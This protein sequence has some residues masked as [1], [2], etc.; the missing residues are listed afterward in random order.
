MDISDGA[1]RGLASLSKKK[2][3]TAAMGTDPEAEL[4]QG[5]T[6]KDY[7]IGEAIEEEGR[8]VTGEE[9]MTFFRLKQ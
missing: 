6:I 2:P 8:E 4:I 5:L 3:L 9:L 7:L 1:G